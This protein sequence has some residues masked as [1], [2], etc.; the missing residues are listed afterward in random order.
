MVVPPLWIYLLWQVCCLYATLSLSGVTLSFLN[1]SRYING[2]AK[3]HYNES[4]HFLCVDCNTFEPF[5]YVYFDTFRFIE[6]TYWSGID[7]LN[8]IDLLNQLIDWTLINQ[9][10]PLT[11]TSVMI[12]WSMIPDLDILNSYVPN[13]KLSTSEYSIFPV[14]SLHPLHTP[15]APSILTT[16]VILYYMVAPTPWF[17]PSFHRHENCNGPPP[18]NTTNNP[19]GR[20]QGDSRSINRNRSTSRTT[21]VSGRRIRGVTKKEKSKNGIMSKMCD[22]NINGLRN[23]GNTCFMNAVLQSLR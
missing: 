9:F 2:H 7:S 21:A 19:N 14:Y 13:Y 11:V 10:L 1:T 23:L 8:G 15:F 4:G 5:W 17:L 16:I 12:M 20:K 22:I 6:Q 3:N 18:S